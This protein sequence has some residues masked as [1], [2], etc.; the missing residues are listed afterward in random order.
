MSSRFLSLPL[1]FLAVACNGDDDD[2]S[3]DGT[4]DGDADTDTDSDT[5]TDTDLD[6]D[7]TIASIDPPNGAEL[8]PL[9]SEIVVAFSAPIPADANW[10]VHVNGAQGAATLAADCSSATWT[11]TGGTL[12]PETSI[13]VEAEVCADSVT[14]SFLTL[15]AP[16]DISEAEHNTYVLEWT[17]ISLDEPPGLFLIED[18]I[19]IELVLL[20]LGAIDPVTL[21]VDAAAAVGENVADPAPICESAVE[22]IADFELNPYF[23]FGPETLSFV[24]DEGAGTTSDAEDF[25]LV[26]RVMPGGL[27]LTDLRISA[28]LATEEIAPGGETCADLEIALQGTCEPCAISVTGE[29]LFVAG[30]APSAALAP[31]G[32]DIVATCAL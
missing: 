22:G 12:P 23:R 10:S 27:E 18:E 7:V 16:V 8:V 5:D 26:A 21:D 24:V 3:P 25:T 15:P 32:V 30:S 28:L 29:C 20:E 4:V 14:S 6:C 17:D 13:I 9:D 2:D 31:P 1:L 19:T 11:A